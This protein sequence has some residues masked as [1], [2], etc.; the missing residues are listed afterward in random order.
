MKGGGAGEVPGLDQAEPGPLAQA[1]SSRD[2]LGHQHAAGRQEVGHAGSPG[3]AAGGGGRPEE[4]RV[5][6]DG[7]ERGRP[8]G[9][10]PAHRGRAV[11]PPG[12]GDGEVAGLDALD[13]DRPAETHREALVSRRAVDVRGE[14]RDVVAAPDERPAQAVDREDRAAVRP[15]R[16]VGGDDVEKFHGLAGPRSRSRPMSAAKRRR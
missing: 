1:P 13:V 12:E 8:L 7:V 5:E 6:V 11:E 4:D 9:E 16:D 10:G 2:E 14:D 3:G 15:G